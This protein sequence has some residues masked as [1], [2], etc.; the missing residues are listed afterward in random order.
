MSSADDTPRHSLESLAMLAGLT[1]RT[2][3][4]YIQQGLVDRPLGEKRGAYYGARHLEQLL[5]VRRWV[6]AG[7]SLERIAE[8]MA[9]AP[10]D[11]A[12]R[13]A[14]PGSVEVWSRVTLADG[15]ELHLEPGRAGLGAEQVRRLVRRITEAYRDVRSNDKEDS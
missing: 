13:V 5:Q 8:L 15:L 12:P 2:V 14:K 7:L 4:Y 3:R 11:P 6:D 10:D 1:P 9:G